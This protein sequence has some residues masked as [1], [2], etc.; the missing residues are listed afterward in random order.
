M[1]PY[2]KVHEEEMNKCKYR[3]SVCGACTILGYES[4]PKI[5]AYNNSNDN[6]VPCDLSLYKPIKEVHQ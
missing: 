1:F 3:D 4:C 5:I 6:N 2:S